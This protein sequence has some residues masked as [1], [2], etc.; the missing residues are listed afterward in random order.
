M[1]GCSTADSTR[2]GVIVTGMRGGVLMTEELLANGL[3]VDGISGSLV[4]G[5]PSINPLAVPSDPVGGS[6][7]V[8]GIAAAWV[9]SVVGGA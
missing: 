8:G 7:V 9:C 6:L 4:A 1:A 2:L 5:H 3:P